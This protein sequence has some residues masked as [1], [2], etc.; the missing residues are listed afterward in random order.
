[1]LPKHIEK[2]P[3][4]ISSNN[5]IL[6]NVTSVYSVFV[7]H[8]SPRPND[9]TGVQSLFPCVL[10]C[11]QAWSVT[12]WHQYSPSRPGNPYLELNPSQ[13]CTIDLSVTSHV[14]ITK[15]QDTQTQTANTA[16]SLTLIWDKW[17]CC[18]VDRKQWI[19]FRQLS[20][21]IQRQNTNP[22]HG[23]FSYWFSYLSTV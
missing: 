17:W 5:M 6:N 19:P 15:Q 9:V 10:V 16:R 12:E 1:M 4:H 22:T 14:L 8:S 18:Y 11:F 2:N 7:F 13:P 3:N 23:A 20:D 21:C